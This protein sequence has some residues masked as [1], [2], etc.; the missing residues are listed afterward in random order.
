M[1]WVDVIILIILAIGLFKGLANG[2]VRGLFGL[3]AVVLGIM[4][5]AGNYEQ[6]QDLLLSKLQIEPQWQAILSFMVIFAVTMLLVNVVGRIISRAM[7]LAALGWM[8]RLAGGL[9]GL[10]MACLFVGVVLLLLVMGGLHTMTGVTRSAVAPT[11]IKVVDTVV[12]YAPDAA[13]ET[14]EGH[15]VK[16]RL[17]W[18]KAKQ[19][20]P[21]KEE[22]DD[23]QTVAVLPSASPRTPKIGVAT[24][25]A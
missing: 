22:E 9:L 2:F 24:I 11:V 12:R 10:V 8:D 15:Y 16:L 17:E 21:E 7:K 5:A 20:A 19:E 23:E 1:N 25:V 13:R 3:A 14:I 6:V 18:E 4:F